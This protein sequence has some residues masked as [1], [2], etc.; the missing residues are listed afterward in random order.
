MLFALIGSVLYLLGCALL[1]GAY[2][3]LDIVLL[4]HRARPSRWCSSPLALMT[5]GLPA[6][7][8][9]FPLHLWLP[10]AHAGA[11]AAASAL[12][13]ALVVKG[14][15]FLIVRLW[16]DVLPGIAG[17]AGGAIAGGAGAPRRSSSA[18]CWRCG[19]RG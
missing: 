7:T 5:A 18:A 12:L 19:R 11:P 1:Y 3:T 4:A 8:A 16:F 15:F 14:S 13:S 17:P 9:L 10:P 6:K 2:G